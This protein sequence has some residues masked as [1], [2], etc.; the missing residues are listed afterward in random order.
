MYQLK[1][2]DD[3]FFENIVANKT[4]FLNQKLLPFYSK[5]TELFY[6]VVALGGGGDVFHPL[7][8]IRF[9]HPRALNLGELIAF[10]MF[11]K[12]C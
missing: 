9:R 11:Y 5:S 10:I 12:I 4:K 7:R 6:L 3:S 8:K 1:G 2:N